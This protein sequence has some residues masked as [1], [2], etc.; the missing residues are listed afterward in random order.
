MVP[1]AFVFKIIDLPGY[2]IR[3]EMFWSK[4]SGFNYHQMGRNE[5]FRQNSP[6]MYYISRYIATLIKAIPGRRG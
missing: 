2:Q 5:L 4:L 3:L 6:V 1:L